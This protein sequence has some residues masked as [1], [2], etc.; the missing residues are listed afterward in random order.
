MPTLTVAQLHHCCLF[1]LGPQLEPGT[2]VSL[3][4]MQKA[5]RL[6]RQPSNL[7]TA[8]WQ[9]ALTTFQAPSG[10]K[11]AGVGMQLLGLKH[12]R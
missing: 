9:I 8:A 2:L 1:H 11:E 3:G 4:A 6:H 10:S 5:R 12:T 7:P